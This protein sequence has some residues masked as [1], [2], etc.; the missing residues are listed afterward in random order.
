MSRSVVSIY[1]P[2]MALRVL[3]VSCS[4]AEERLQYAKAR[5][6]SGSTYQSENTVDHTD[7]S[8]EAKTWFIEPSRYDEL[9]VDAI[10]DYDF[11]EIDDKN[12]MNFLKGHRE[13]IGTSVENEDSLGSESCPIIG[14]KP[15]SRI[16]NELGSAS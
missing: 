2:G 13:G 15:H 16:P 11:L 12:R 6:A 14:R 8:S 1:T 7:P 5:R 10:E 4:K 9:V 3:C